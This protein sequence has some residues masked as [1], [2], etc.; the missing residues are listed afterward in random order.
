MSIITSWFFH[1]LFLPG[2]MLHTLITKN[3]IARYDLKVYTIDYLEIEHK[4]SQILYEAPKTLKEKYVIGAGP[5]FIL[6]GLSILLYYAA[7]T[8]EATTIISILFIYSGMACAFASFPSTEI[9]HELW[10][11]TQQ[12]IKQGDILAIIFCIPI[13]FFN[14]VKFFYIFKLELLFAVGLFIWLSFKLDIDPF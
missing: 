14:L 5:F 11:A 4:K 12:G 3:L 9:S 2:R 8:V 7:L 10:K 1:I 13:A 6:S